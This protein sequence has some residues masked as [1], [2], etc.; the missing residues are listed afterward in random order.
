MAGSRGLPLPAHSPGAPGAGEPGEITS[1]PEYYR[2]A[3][4]L[5]LE[6]V[7]SARRTDDCPAADELTAPL[8][9]ALGLV[10]AVLADDRPL[11]RSIRMLV[12]ALGAVASVA[13]DLLN[14]RIGVGVRRLCYLADI[15]AAFINGTLEEGI[16]TGTDDWDRD[17]DS[18]DFSDWLIANG[19]TPEAARCALV[20]TLCYDL[21]FAYRFGD[22]HRPT[23]SAAT[24]VR[25]LLRVLLDYKGA[26]AY[27]PNAGMGDIMF[28]PLYQV[29]ERR[30]VRFEFFHRVTGL[31]L[32]ETRTRV[33]VIDMVS[34]V[35]LRHP[36]RGY[37]PLVTIG[38]LAC[39][40]SAP[41]FEKI[42][43]A[44]H[45]AACRSEDTDGTAVSLRDGEEFDVAVLAIP[46]CAHRF[47]CQELI[48]ARLEWAEMSRRIETVCT[49]SLQAWLL[50]SSESLGFPAPGGVLGG[51]V[52][53]FDTCADMSHLISQESWSQPVR[54]AFFFCNA[55][56]ASHHGP[57]EDSHRI[58]LR[59][60][61]D[62]SRAGSGPR[63]TRRHEPLSHVLQLGSGG[64]RRA[65][66][67]DLLACE[68]LSRAK[69]CSVHPRIARV[70]ASS[71][72][73]RIR[74][75][76]HRR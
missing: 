41:I 42:A 58:A 35:S 67:R 52:E 53:P 44:D 6:Y 48:A 49:Q 75:P 70:P 71:W 36:D 30:G 16:L 26:V 20:R 72:R 50:A 73:E 37:E 33:G 29:L 45:A 51:F 27:K 4:A 61:H 10:D 56:P 25:G 28:A 13:R 69:I 62:V 18:H 57:G 43:P 19:A 5:I 40:P 12:P 31:R 68:R 21:P 24:A 8:A 23:C 15:A 55:L 22:P 17:L 59:R 39:W 2:R 1:L 46:V 32:D 64:R 66:A 11:D 60:R 47:I 34:Q 74:K 54:S 63:P 3:L 7:R 65:R 38:G 76:V 9:S 14:R